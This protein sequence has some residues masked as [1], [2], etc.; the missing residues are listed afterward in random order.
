M[1]RL[2][3][4]LSYSA[5]P[6]TADPKIHCAG[7]SPNRE[8][9]P[10]PSP[11]HGDALPTELLG[12]IPGLTREPGGSPGYTAEGVRQKSKTA[13]TAGPFPGLSSPIRGVL[14]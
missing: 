10:R 14:M 5:M 4:Q 12:R 7:Q 1:S 8:S 13:S 9:N 3:Y 11:Y 6:G 2:L